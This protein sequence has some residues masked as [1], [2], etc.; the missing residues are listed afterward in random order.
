VDYVQGYAIDR[1]VPIDDYFAPVGPRSTASVA[2][3][4]LSRP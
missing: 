4:S 1:P 2:A 3:A